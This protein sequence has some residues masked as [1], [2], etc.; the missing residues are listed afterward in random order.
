MAATIQEDVFEY[1]D[2]PVA[3][4]TAAHTPD[5]ARAPADGGPDPPGRG[6]RRG[7]SGARSSAGRRARSRRRTVGPD[8]CGHRAG[9]RRSRAAGSCGLRPSPRPRAASAAFS[10]AY[11]RGGVVRRRGPTRRRTPRS[12]AGY[13]SPSRRRARASAASR[14][15]RS[16]RRVGKDE[17]GQIDGVAGDT[18]LG[19]VDRDDAAPRCR[20][21]CA[22]S[23]TQPRLV[24]G[25]AVGAVVGGPAAT[26]GR[27]SVATIARATSSA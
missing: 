4:L 24:I 13:R 11:R 25:L 27:S 6:H 14:R 2:A 17:I 23:S 22:Q 21:T 19:L 18:E 10:R 7:R 20:A 26:S 1:L 12:C 8:W 9:T 3:R 16:A 5:P 15:A